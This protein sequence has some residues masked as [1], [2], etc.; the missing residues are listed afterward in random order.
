MR[1][2]QLS[3]LCADD[4]DSVGENITTIERQHKS[5]LLVISKGVAMT[6]K[7]I[8]AAWACTVMCCGESG[9]QS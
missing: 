8:K 2:A 4:S 1:R 9:G 7:A 6:V 3:L 5:A